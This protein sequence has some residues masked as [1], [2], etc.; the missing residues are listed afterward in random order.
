MALLF[1]ISIMPWTLNQLL[2][3]NAIS[4]YDKIMPWT[5][6]MKDYDNVKM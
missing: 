1:M 3:D 2:S 6:E 5:W 4:L